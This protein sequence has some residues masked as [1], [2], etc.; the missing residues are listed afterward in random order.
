MVTGGFQF[1]TGGIR[2]EYAMSEAIGDP[3]GSRMGFGAYYA[4]GP[5]TVVG[6]LS[7]QDTTLTGTQDT[8]NVGASGVFGP[9]TVRVGFS[10]TENDPGTGAAKQNS[11]E[12]TLGVQWAASPQWNLRFGYY[13]VKYE[14][15]GT[16]VGD[17]QLM[18]F[19]VDYV[20]SKRTV[21]YLAFD[22]N[23]F[24][25]VGWDAAGTATANN[26]VLG[27]ASRDGATG[28]SIGIAHTF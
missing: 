14:L 19:A 27:V 12:M 16:E 17:R 11:P 4:F 21:A 22:K 2:A 6:A 23:N 1:G 7:T 24:S 20:L 3:F 28:I 9:F 15:G 25:G 8:T 18:I 10:E 13:D 26:A 5:V